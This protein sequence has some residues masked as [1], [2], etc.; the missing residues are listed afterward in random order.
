MENAGTENILKLIPTASDELAAKPNQ[1]LDHL[2]GDPGHWL[3]GNMKSL[4]PNLEP[5]VR[6]QQAL[7]GNCFT[8]G[9]FRNTRVVMMV[10]PAANERILLDKEDNFSNH[11]GWEVLQEFFGRNVLVRDFADHRQHRRLITPV[12]KP[13]ALACYLQ[14]M[15]SIVAATLNDYEGP[16]DAYRQTKVMA[17]D[18]AVEVFAGIP[19]GPATDGWNRDLSI[20]LANAM[21]HRIRLPFT[22][23]SRGLRARDRLRRRLGDE[24]KLLRAPGRQA[25]DLAD[26]V[27]LFSRLA[28]QKDNDGAILSDSDVIDHM[29]GM[30]FAAHDTTASSLAMIFWL[31]AK[32]PEWQD[33][34]R[35]RCQSLCKQTGSTSLAYEDLNQLPELE[36]TFKEALRQYA[37]LQLLPR[38]SVRAFEFQGLQVPANTAIFL[39]PQ[40]VHYNPRFFPNPEVFDPTRFSDAEGAKQT[41]N[42]FAFIPFGKGS[43]MCM[44]MHFATMEIKAVLYQLLLSKRLSIDAGCEIDDIKMEYLPIVRPG[45]PMMVHFSPL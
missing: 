45:K 31:L 36:W 15:N 37:P 13:A 4:L 16:I 19:S 40:A 12:F 10:G 6:K 24:L 7:H 34:L 29:F 3:T 21:A 17:L 43:H 25:K 18:I 41:D 2:P 38:R 9:L 23:Y 22:R 5:F 42:P 33:R 8:L 28:T 44:G 39:V 11:W 26:R 27:D 1:Q 32:H 20:V 14:Q 30:L 35:K